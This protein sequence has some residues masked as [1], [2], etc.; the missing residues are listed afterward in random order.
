MKKFTISDIAARAGVS[1][2]TVSRILNGK[3]NVTAKT[4]ENVLSVISELNFDIPIQILRS[5]QPKFGMAIAGYDDITPQSSFFHEV[6]AGA[7]LESDQRRATFSFAPL[8]GADGADSELLRRGDLDGLIVAGVPIADETVKKLNRA[9]YPTVFIGRYLDYSEPLNYVTPDNVGGGR[10]AANFLFEAG[11]RNICV[12]N[13]PEKINVFR[14]RI[15]GVREF[16]SERLAAAIREMTNFNEEAGYEAMR[17]VLNEKNRPTA[18]L[19]LSDWMAIGAMR[20]IV[21][22]GLNIPND[23]SVMGFSDLPITEILNPP[24]TTIRIPQRKLGGLAVQLLDS[25]IRKEIQGPVGMIVPLEIVVR[26]STKK[27]E[28]SA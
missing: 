21:E 22:A 15:L 27:I 10:I 7:G 17:A 4:R 13:G 23:I 8:Y 6:I 1:T 5:H 20:A 24:L 28:A 9:A 12:L 2:A 19:A 16:F 18:V 26:E 3:D 14:D 25:L 11:H